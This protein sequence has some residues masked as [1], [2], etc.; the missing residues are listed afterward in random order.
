[1]GYR[2]DFEAYKNEINRRVI[3]MGGLA[4]VIDTLESGEIPTLYDRE[5]RSECLY[6][7]AIVDHLSRVN[8]LPVCSDYA[9]L[10]GLIPESMRRS[11]AESEA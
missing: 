1:M 3:D 5:R 8:G 11:I 6:L 2:P 10:R 4:F 7:L 9:E